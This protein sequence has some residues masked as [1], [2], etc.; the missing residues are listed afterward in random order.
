MNNELII[1]RFKRSL[2]TY[3]DNAQIQEIMATNLISLLPQKTFNSILEIGCGTGI[4]TK[5]CV[6]NLKFTNYTA[7]DIV[8]ECQNYTHKINPNIN[9]LKGDITTI[10]LPQKYDLI[11]SNAVFQWFDSPNET[12]TKLKQN[13]SP[14]GILLFSTF[15][16]K[17]FY[18]LKEILN[19][20]IDYPLTN[21]IHKEEIYELTFPNCHEMLKH[22][23]NTGVNAITEYKLTRKK[24]DE[25]NNK[26]IENYGQVKLTYN[27]IYVIL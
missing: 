27:P 7:N 5:K 19:I 11:I 12:I 8:E 17:N 25:L 16:N 2:S 9:F 18:E 1:K 22:I 21:N 14:N 20:S 15:G 24:L 26:F 10:D 6:E 3:D 23:K 4:L 13:L